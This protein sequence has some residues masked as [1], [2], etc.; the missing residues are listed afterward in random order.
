MYL[1]DRSRA[2]SWYFKE[3][4]VLEKR[5][6]EMCTLGTISVD[7]WWW[8]LACISSSLQAYDNSFQRPVGSFPEQRDVTYVDGI[9]SRVL[10]VQWREEVCV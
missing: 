8:E 3:V 9:N 10:R 4:F 5:I 6:V 7:V 1:Q 2:S